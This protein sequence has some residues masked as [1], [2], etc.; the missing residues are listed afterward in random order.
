MCIRDSAEIDHSRVEDA[1]STELRVAR[2]EA[3]DL[4]HK[5]QLLAQENIELE[6]KLVPYRVKV[7]DLKALIAKVKN[8][9]KRSADREVFLGKVEK[10][11]DDTMAKLAEANEENGKIAAELAQVQA[12]SKKVTEDLL[13]ARET[14]EEL[15]KQAEA[16]ERGA[17]ET[18]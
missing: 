15:K 14:I 6:S 8:L 18:D 9:E 12:E 16:A 3:T 10:E 4:R 17:K 11:R 1:M 5:V 7:P 13:Q 2:K